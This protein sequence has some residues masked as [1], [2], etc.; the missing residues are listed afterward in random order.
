MFAIAEEELIYASRASWACRTVRLSWAIRFVIWAAFLHLPVTW[1]S[2]NCFEGIEALA[3]VVGL[4]VSL[5]VWMLTSLTST[6]LYTISVGRAAV[7]LLGLTRS[8]EGWGPR[9]QRAR[10][11]TSR[12]SRRSAAASASPSRKPT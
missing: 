10:G 1:I 12:A 5:G 8:L 9:W 2:N 6:L 3:P 11:G 4:R 7:V